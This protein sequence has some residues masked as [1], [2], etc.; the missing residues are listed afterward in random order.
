MVYPDCMYTPEWYIDHV[1][2]TCEYY[3]FDQVVRFAD[4]QVV[5]FVK[6]DDIILFPAIL[7]YVLLL[8]I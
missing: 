1:Y 6:I 5:S 4:R 7:K 3:C 8:V 2:Y